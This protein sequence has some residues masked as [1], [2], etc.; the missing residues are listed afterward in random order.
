MGDGEKKEFMGN[1][2]LQD[3]IKFYGFTHHFNLNNRQ[4]LR[5]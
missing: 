1:V 2:D 4:I 3:I 5:R